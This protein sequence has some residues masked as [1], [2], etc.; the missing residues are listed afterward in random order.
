MPTFI[1]TSLYNQNM[2]YIFIIAIGLFAYLNSFSGGFILD[3]SAH[4]LNNLHIKFDLQNILYSIKNLFHNDRAFLNFTLML[5]YS[6]G[7]LEPF[8]YHLFNL[9]I[10]ILSSIFLFKIAKRFLTQNLAFISAILW[11][12]HP[13]NTQAVTYIIQRA[14]SLTGCF[15]LAAIY[16]TLCFWQEKKQNKRYLFYVAICAILAAFTKQTVA[17][18]IITIFLLHY[19]LYQKKILG[20][21]Q[22]FKQELLNSKLLYT[23]LFFANILLVFNYLFFKPTQENS[24]GFSLTL[25]T[26]LEYLQTQF[27]VITH[28]IRLLIIPHPLI[29]DYHWPVAKSLFDVYPYA[30]FI[31]LLFIFSL[32]TFLKK[33]WVGF[34]GVFFFVNLALTSSIIPIK[35]LAFEYRLY[36]SSISYIFILV[37]IINRYCFFIKNYIFIILVIVFGFLTINRNSDY[38]SATTIWEKNLKHYP[39]NPRALNELAMTYLATGNFKKANVYFLKAIEVEQTNPGPFINLAFIARQNQEFDLALDYLKRAE[40]IDPSYNLLFANFG[41]LFLELKDYQNA[42]TMYQKLL[43][44]NSKE[45][46]ALL[47]I[48]RVFLFT[49]QFSKAQEHFQQILAYDKMNKEALNNLGTTFHNSGKYLQAINYYQKSLKQEPEN[50]EV[51]FNIANSYFAN[52]DFLQAKNYYI[53]LLFYFPNHPLIIERLKQ[54]KDL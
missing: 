5:N 30:I 12:I 32:Y 3:D 28:Y 10:H 2:H 33:Q 16:F 46:H 11:M 51:M 41:D 31:V 34:L 50:L 8:G 4:I 45:I 42:M 38:A 36:L 39:N 22:T 52:K 15:Y 17:T 18:L 48:G 44:K 1:A 13:I 47:G 53:K 23:I 37:L 43:Q 20:L 24:L 7:K 6:L 21:G 35:D 49:K 26:P 54:L 14:E 27:Q 25:F 9:S 29:M 40:K 19:F